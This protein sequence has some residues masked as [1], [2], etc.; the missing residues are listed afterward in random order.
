MHELREFQRAFGQ[1]LLSVPDPADDEI[2]GLPGLA[3]RIHRNTTLKGLVDALAANYPT[4]CQLVGDEWFQ[5]SAIEYVRT[6]PARSPV[7]ALY[8]ERFPAFL[9][10]FA[11]AAEFPYLPE[12]A[13]ID[14]LWIESLTA[15]DMTPLMSSSLA[16]LSAA[17]AARQRVSLHPATRLAWV[18]H[19]AAT[20]WI[21]HRAPHS[22]E[23]TIA[24]T[25]E[26]ILLTRHQGTIEH[27]LLDAAGFRFLECLGDGMPLG[28]AAVAALE[29][30]ASAHIAGVL[31][32]SIALGAFADLTENPL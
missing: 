2:P 12:V 10:D 9:A 7:L 27:Q 14:R 26:G 18:R 21:H 15:L 22:S 24:D 16:G 25:A 23:L 20:I 32:Q 4:V 29:T 5:A 6:H 13:R 17:T 30:D 8:G 28:E 31:S 3:L 1:A 11:A 19:S